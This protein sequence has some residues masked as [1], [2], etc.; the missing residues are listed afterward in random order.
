MTRYSRIYLFSRLGVVR[1]DILIMN[2]IYHI[3]MGTFGL[4]LAIGVDEKKDKKEGYS[5]KH[6]ASYRYNSDSAPHL[7]VIT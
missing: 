2:R 1:I 7:I 3:G 4:R 6:L 5:A